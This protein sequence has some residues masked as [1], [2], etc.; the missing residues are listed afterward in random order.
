MPNTSNENNNNDTNKPNDDQRD[1]ND[2][3]R[4]YANSSDNNSNDSA[5]NYEYDNGEH[6]IVGDSNPVIV[7]YTLNNT[8]D[9]SG[10]EIVN[11]QGTD[12]SGSIVNIT[13]MHVTDPSSNVNITEN[14]VETVTIYDDDDDPNSQNYA[15]INQIK[16]YAGQ[17]QC[18]NFHGKGT[19]DDYANLFEAA[20]KIAN[21]SQQIQLDVDIEGFTEFG[22]A[23]DQLSQLFASFTLK[24]QNVNIIN[25]TTFLTSIV[26]A[27]GK[28]VNLSHVFGKFKETIL[29]TTTIQIPKST[30]ETAVILNG[31][32]SEI[33]CAMNYINYFVSPSDQVLPDAE[34]ST[35]E[36]NIIATAVTTI[37][38][39]NTICE[40]GVSI[41]MS[42]NT[43]VQN[44]KAASD[45]L[46]QTTLKLQNITSSLQSKLNSYM[47][48]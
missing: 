44:I 24:L 2:T 7:N 34:L 37:D 14:L 23:A 16:D 15:L 43:D 10:V 12:A 31:V 40:Q 27:L 18:S 3:S 11:Q 36:Q 48:C 42:N 26:T 20:C 39:W 5:L 45:T 1:N 6:S 9:V 29:T 41:A 28:I 19:I 32:M 25:D 46:K 13:T 22:A 17:I 30:H 47:K 8:T 21:E 38:N 4:S 35:E 33:N